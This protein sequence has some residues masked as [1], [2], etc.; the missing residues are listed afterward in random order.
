MSRTY[1]H[2]D[3]RDNRDSGFITGWQNELDADGRFHEAGVFPRITT[4]EVKELES[5]T[6]DEVKSEAIDWID[7]GYCAV[8]RCSMR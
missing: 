5:A 3:N 4:E 8:M 1:D 7:D 6:L 2:R